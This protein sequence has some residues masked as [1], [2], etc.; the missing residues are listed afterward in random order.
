MT[1]CQRTRVLGCSV[2]GMKA[3]FYYSIKNHKLLVCVYFCQC[4]KDESL[5]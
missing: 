2:V 4:L 1:G 5:V 3:I